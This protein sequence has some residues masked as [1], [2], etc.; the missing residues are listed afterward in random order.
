MCF[1]IPSYSFPFKELRE[2]K[3]AYPV[4]SV[5]KVQE[6]RIIVTLMRIDGQEKQGVIT[7]PEGLLRHPFID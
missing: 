5:V 1:A 6:N 3:P 7:M 2:G 4:Q